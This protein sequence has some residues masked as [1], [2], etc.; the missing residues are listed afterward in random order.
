M[1]L[2]IVIGISQ[3]D[4]Q[5]NLPACK[6]D[7]NYFYKLLDLSDKY[8]NILYIDQETD[9]NSIMNKIDDFILEYLTSE[10]NEIVIY[11][12]GHG[13]YNDDEF[14]FCTSNVDAS[15][16]NSTSIS[17]TNLDRVIRKISPNTYVKIIDACESGNSYIKKVGSRDQIF[18]KNYDGFKNCYFFS[19]STNTQSSY[20]NDNISY[21]TQKF[22]ELVKKIIIEEKQKEIK[23]RQIS[24]YLADAFANNSIQTP[25]FVLQGSLSEIFLTNNEQLEAYLKEIKLESLESN[26]GVS[27]IEGNIEEVTKLIPTQEEAEKFKV[28]LIE[29]LKKHSNKE[30]PKLLKKYGYELSVN[31]IASNTV[32]NKTKIGNWLLENKD[33][34]FIFAKEKYSRK[35]SKNA[36]ANI[37]SMLSDENVEYEISSFKLNVSENES[38]YQF[39]LF[40]E[41]HLPKYCYQLVVMY[42]L[43]KI[44]IFYDF[45]FSYP[46]NW[47]EYSEYNVLDKVNILCVNINNNDE[48][49][50][51]A[52]RISTEF[53]DFCEGHTKKYLEVLFEKK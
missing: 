27:E 33:K 10:I 37:A 23:Y 26:N 40:S 46:K 8:E 19:S 50:N 32:F 5:K 21:F 30:V 7:A 17:N 34:L 9:S 44:Y 2:A 53:L 29:S 36:I 24:G 25:F 42:S 4:K 28:I 15:N 31:N 1:N 41:T 43:T 51:A 49:K 3:Y 11:F 22:I 14:Y 38:I 45:S 6:N 18:R 12:S 52:N 35:Q 48:L 47:E 39:E 13:Y 20:A 16:I